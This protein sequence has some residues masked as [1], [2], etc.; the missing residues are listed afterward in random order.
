VSEDL[1]F[2]RLEPSITAGARSELE[3]LV[4]QESRAHWARVE[5]KIKAVIRPAPRWFPERIWRWLA[6]KFLAVKIET[7]S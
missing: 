4:D 1:P 5:D 6:V 3:R 7:W 2:V